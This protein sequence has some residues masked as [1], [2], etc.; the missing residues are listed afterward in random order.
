MR[1]RRVRWRPSS[2]DGTAAAVA[3][4]VA[5]LNAEVI[6]AVPCE[7]GGCTDAGTQYLN[8][9]WCERHLPIMEHVPSM[10]DKQRW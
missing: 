7:F 9:A 2:D 3:L 10:Y 4:L 6:P 1:A 8:G 5:L